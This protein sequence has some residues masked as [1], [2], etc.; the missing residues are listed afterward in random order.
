MNFY[1][2]VTTYTE[3]SQDDFHKSL[4]VNTSSSFS[5]VFAALH[6]HPRLLWRPCSYPQSKPYFHPFLLIKCP[7]FSHRTTVL[8]NPVS[9]LLSQPSTLRRTFWRHNSVNRDEFRGIRAPILGVLVVSLLT[10]PHL[11]S[12]SR[13]LFFKGR[14]PLFRIF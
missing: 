9:A 4:W 3:R 8:S 10:F 13:L 7:H 11:S 2:I 5:S 1:R 14:F 12:I 6:V